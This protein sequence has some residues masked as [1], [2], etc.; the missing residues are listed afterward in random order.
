MIRSLTILPALLCAAA[1]VSAQAPPAQDKP[2]APSPDRPAAASPAPQEGAKPAGGAVTYT[3]CLKP[4]ATPG[5]WVL[6]SAEASAAKP[7]DAP[8][9]TSGAMKTTLN[10]QP[11]AGADLKPHAD[12]K[13]SVTGSISP[14]KSPAAPGAKPAQEFTVESFKMV[15]ATCP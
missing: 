2:A 11:K 9:G 13:I 12:H 14:A 6:E 8:V 7:G 5:S 1:L 4:G 10:L 3:G 15:S